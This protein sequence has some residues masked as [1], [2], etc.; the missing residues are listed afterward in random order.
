[1]NILRANVFRK[2]AR[3]EACLFVVMLPVPVTAA[4]MQSRFSLFSAFMLPGAALVTTLRLLLIIS[5][6]NQVAEA[7]SASQHCYHAKNWCLMQCVTEAIA[8]MLNV[9]M[10][11]LNKAEGDSQRTHL[12]LLTFFY[13]AYLLILQLFDYLAKRHLLRGFGEIWQVC[14]GD[15]A[16]S[17][18]LRLTHI[19]LVLSCIL[20]LLLIAVFAMMPDS[21]KAIRI[22]A[23]G[24]GFFVLLVQL[25]MTRHAYKT[26]HLLAELSE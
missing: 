8:L 5:L 13:L 11:V 6:A 3:T 24:T 15:A 25:R 4:V 19:L 21:W 2:I 1:M 7:A 17:R 18:Q 20:F 16:Q 9:I 10:T 14:G 12:L 22:L 26:A 23:A